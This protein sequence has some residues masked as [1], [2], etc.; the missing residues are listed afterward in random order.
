MVSVIRRRSLIAVAATAPAWPLSGARAEGKTGS[1]VYPV[2]VPTYEVQFVAQERGF[3]KDEGYELQ[4]DPGGAA[5]ALKTREIMASRQ[6]R[7]PP[8]PT[9]C[10][11]CSS[12]RTAGRRGR[13]TPSTSA[14]PAC[15]S[16][17]ARISTT[18]ASTRCRRPPLSSGPTTSARSSASPRWAAPRTC[19]RTTSWSKDGPRRQGRTWVGADRQY[20][21]HYA[22]RSALKTK[23]GRRAVEHGHLGSRAGDG[24]FEKNG[25]GKVIYSPS[26]EKTWNAV[27]GGPVPVNVNF[28]LAATIEKEPEKVQAFTNAVWRAM[29]GMDSPSAQCNPDKIQAHP[30]SASS[31][32]SP[33]RARPIS[34]RS[35]SSRTS[36]PTGTA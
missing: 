11:C 29:A 8:S 16:P 19:G 22:G 31:K 32:G 28:C 27:I 33:H 36:L 15:A 1:A 14:R 3:F 12:T 21:R 9:S 18:R 24:S 4:A 23:L 30:S 2:A 13:S 10:M 17:S 6:A 20:R 5:T 26:D 7:F 25:W 34:W 35:A